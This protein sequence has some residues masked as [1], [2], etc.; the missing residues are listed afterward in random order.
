MGS[1]GRLRQHN[2]ELA[3]GATQTAR[4][5][6]WRVVLTITG[7]HT[8]QQALQFEFAWRR[9]HR[10]MRA[11]YTLDGRRTSLDALRR[12]ERWSSRAPLASEVPLRV[13]EDGNDPPLENQ[14]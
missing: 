6:P 3:G 14:R 11:A 10:R 5:R 12:R 9:V 1:P 4:H 7:F 2:G 8:R 13:H